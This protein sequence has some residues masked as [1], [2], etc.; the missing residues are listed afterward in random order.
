MENI[1]NAYAN[2]TVLIVVKEYLQLIQD[3]KEY[4]ADES[5][6]CSIVRL[7]S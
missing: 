6:D 4:N 1:G 2:L 3:Q 5:Y 7:V